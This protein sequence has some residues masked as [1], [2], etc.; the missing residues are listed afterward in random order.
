MLIQQTLERL[1]E[2]RLTG[3]A[4]ALEEQLAV[5]DTQ[6]LGFDDRLAFLVE[7]E[8]TCRLDR[9]L[10]RHLHLAKLR[11]AACVEDLDFRSPRGLD[12]SLLLRLAGCEWIAAH[13][14]VLI[15]GATGTGKSFLACALGHV[16]CRGGFRVRFQRADA[17][18]RQ[19]RQSRLDNSR[20]M[21]MAELCAIDLLI[22][23]DFAL[24]PMTR[25]ESRDVYQLFVERNA[26]AATIITSNR[27]TAE[28]VAVFDDTLL[29]QSAVERV[30][31]VDRRPMAHIRRAAELG[32][33]DHQRHAEIDVCK[34]H[35]A[36]RV[37]PD[38]QGG[39]GDSALAG[40]YI[41][42][43]LGRVDKLQL[44]R[45]Q[46][47]PREGRSGRRARHDRLEVGRDRQPE[48][49]Q[50]VRAPPPSPPK[51]LP[52]APQGSVP[53]RPT[54]RSPSPHPRRH[55]SIDHSA[56]VHPPYP[57]FPRSQIAVSSAPNAPTPPPA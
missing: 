41:G 11:L 47:R 46:H 38:R 16:A 2:L 25:D 34:A 48:E 29:G 19:L 56:P 53:A 35:D 17:L 57:F 42:A 43:A 12:K 27:D 15:S 6:A 22:I 54:G 31:I 13:Q 26:R 1:H 21:L 45:V 3:M 40:K 55:P 33:V 36:A 9:R 10:T 5:P 24:E 44:V 51:P 20:D 8:V 7:R 49:P 32:D 23:D 18:L 52:P 30:R 28:W 4:T 37:V 50:P 39:A 14:T